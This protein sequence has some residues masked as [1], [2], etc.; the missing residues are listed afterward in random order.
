MRT[1][2]LAVVCALFLTPT[3]GAAQ[4]AASAPQ[5]GGP[6]AAAAPA[7]APASTAV[8]PDAYVLGVNDEVEI[9]VFGRADT[10]VT[11]RIAE[12][13]TV[14]FP[15]VGA[16]KA[17]GETPRSLATKISRGLKTGGYFTNPIVNVDVKSFISNSVTVF[18]NVNSPGVLPLDRP[19]TV[20]M[21][22]ARAGGRRSDA[23]EYA[24]L[25]NA[26]SGTER[27]IY[28]DDLDAQSGSGV[29]LKAGDTLF[30]PEAEQF[31]VYGQ[32]N[33]PGQFAI[34]RGMTVRQA[35]ARAGGPTL[36]GSEKKVSL[37]RDGK[38]T[39]KISLDELVK[40]KDVLRVGE[41]LF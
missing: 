24:V 9:T 7:A 2:I 11:T 36:G 15:Y 21:M 28:F 18:G 34:Q 17:A 40:A 1:T 6:P 39:K 5:V 26:D 10:T 19:L 3:A 38:L 14:T 31:F 33:S 12:D 13:G 29:L 32:V 4:Q 35:L 22:V 8:N 30:V 23:A 16:V 25:R 20:A 41:R 37:Y 27:R